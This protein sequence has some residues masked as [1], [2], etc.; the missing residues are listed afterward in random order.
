MHK[1]QQEEKEKQFL[2]YVI[3][4]NNQKMFSTMFSIM[5]VMYLPY[6]IIFVQ[7]L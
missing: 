1:Q 3:R 7:N 4:E 6:H 5:Y 2:I